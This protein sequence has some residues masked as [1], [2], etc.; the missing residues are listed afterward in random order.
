MA[1]LIL[2]SGVIAMTG[3]LAVARPS[4]AGPVVAAPTNCAGPGQEYAPV[5]WA[6]SLLAPARVW[7]F[8]RGN[9][10]R[11]AVLDSGVDAAHALLKGRVAAGFD[12]VTAKGRADSD[13]TG[14]GTRVAGV[15]VAQP[16][17]AR[18]FSGLAPAAT[19]L[20]VR[21]L[22]DSGYANPDQADPAVLA[23]AITWAATQGAQVICVPVPAYADSAE[24][25]AA[26]AAALARGIVVV[27]AAG[28]LGG[29]GSANPTPYP[30]AYPGV[31]GVGAVDANAGRWA[32]SQHGEYV[33][34]VAPGDGIVSTQR[35]SGLTEVDGT[36][37]AAGFVAGTVALVREA[38]PELGPDAVAARLAATATPAGDRAP[39]HEYGA[40]IVNPYN[41]VT[42]QLP[43][44]AASAGLPMFRPPGSAVDLAGPER[45]RRAIALTAG[46]ML[47]AAAI[48]IG[49]TVVLRGSRRR[50]R[51]ALAE[52]PP[53][54][55]EPAAPGPPVPL[56]EEEPLG[57]PPAR[58]P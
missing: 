31:L 41:A 11:V 14:S 21:I 10:V 45:R 52:P 49:R 55:V 30:A 50:W 29:P 39:S 57:G 32:G 47:V 37:V 35:L 28:N 36:G 4:A 12:A 38:H 56:F 1:A 42:D 19:I 6:T 9:G 15:I 5:P 54:P 24:L 23:R 43:A 8:A 48:W 26:V 34:L 51:S 53:Q 18:G 33:D 25:R 17:A 3:A 20:P 13:C 7:P 44:P 40:G 46:L 16:S 2:T 27:A 58:R 22:P